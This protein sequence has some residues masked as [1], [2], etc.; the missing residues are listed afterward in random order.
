MN[1][2]GKAASLGGMA[3]RDLSGEVVLQQRHA[4]EGPALRRRRRAVLPAEGNAGSGA[5]REGPCV[6]TGCDQ[7]HRGGWVQVTV[8]AAWTRPWDGVMSGFHQGA[9]GGPWRL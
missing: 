6:G 5:L 1:G 3:G 8:G 9:T 4:D 2:G 7:G